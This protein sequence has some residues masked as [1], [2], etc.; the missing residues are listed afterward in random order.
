M[1]GILSQS[2]S[3]GIVTQKMWTIPKLRSSTAQK[4]FE[5]PN[6]HA[7]PASITL[8]ALISGRASIREYVE[9]LF[10]Q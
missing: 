4:K 3:T 8:T 9:A 5:F 10:N 7:S 2:L 1:S 6:P